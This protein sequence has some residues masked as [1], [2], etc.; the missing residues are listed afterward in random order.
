MN[1]VAEDTSFWKRQIS[2]PLAENGVT[3]TRAYHV[4]PLC[5]PN[6]AS[7]LTG[8]Y[9]SRHGIFDNTGRHLQSHRIDLFAKDLQKAGYRTA[10][11]GKYH[12]GNDP[13][14]RPGY[15]YWVSFSGQGK[16]KDPDI[17]E[18]GQMH[19]VKGYIT[20][21]F[22]DRAVDFIE[23]SDEQPFFVYVA[24]KAVHP[25]GFLGTDGRLDVSKGREFIPADRHVGRYDGKVVTRRKNHGSTAEERLSKPVIARMLS[26]RD[27][28]RTENEGW[29]K[30]FDTGIS[31]HTIQKRAE[32]MLAVDESVGRIVAAVAA[33]GKL[34]NTLIIFT[35][36]NGYWYGEHGLAI[37][38]RLPYEEGLRSPLIISYPG[39]AEAG[40]EE[41]AL[42]LSIDH[43]ATILD[44]AG[45][46]IPG[47]VQGKSY[48]P[49]LT[50]K[51][52]KIRDY[53]Y[54]EYFAYERP[55]PWTVNLDYRVIREDRYKYINW[56]KFDDGEELYDM[57]ADPFELRNLAGEPESAQVLARMRQHLRDKSVE[58][59]GLV[60]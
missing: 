51:A 14:P 28:I 55:F 17:Y 41:D 9:V 33:E 7:L 21:I 45:I 38:R 56:I 19:Q 27:Q 58:V 47:H 37:E 20:D 11:V 2:T 50:G 3:F 30:F 52:G 59:L 34:D 1:G 16:T 15:D 4:T 10:H 35:S 18:D 48:Q 26:L 31:D 43:A 8:Q 22:T 54:M 25:E 57:E 32:M 53:A 23:Q 12:M 13:T 46:D 39:V 42:V 60:D 36:D 29:A 49:L 6:R 40:T 44:V 5:S 24:H